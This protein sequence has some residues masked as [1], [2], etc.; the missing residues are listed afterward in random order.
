[1]MASPPVIDVEAD[2]PLNNKIP[3][4]VHL[5]DLNH[6]LHTRHA[7]GGD[8]VLDPTPSQDP[9][10]PLN[11]TPRRKILSS[12]CAN[13]WA[14][15]LDDDDEKIPRL[16]ISSAPCGRYTWFTGVAVSTVYSVLV[17][18]SKATGITITTLN[19]GTGYMFLFLGFV[20]FSTYTTRV[21]NTNILAAS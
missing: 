9:N 14:Y 7:E 5:V 6:T 2:G 1:M 19:Q 8:I 17:P 15:V 4:T 13:L 18:I 20:F 11:W 12:I 10:D 3:G 21:R 16:I